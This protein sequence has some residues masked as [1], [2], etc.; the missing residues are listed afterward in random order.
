MSSYDS[1]VSVTKE[2][3]FDA[4]HHLEDYE[5]ACANVHGHT[6]K[7]Q[8]TVT[9][10]RNKNGFVID[11]NILRA[12]VRG[13]IID[14]LDHKDLNEV[15]H[16]NPTAENMVVWIYDELFWMIPY[17]LKLSSIKLWETPTSFAEYRGE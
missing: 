3:L 9:G 5:G 12:T 11:F 2:F 8:V 10:V 7:L 15:F 4:A 6:Y 17:P 1:K 16:F 13:A 14:R